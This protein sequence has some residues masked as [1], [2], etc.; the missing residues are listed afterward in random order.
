[1]QTNI[2][3]EA[4]RRQRRKRGCASLEVDTG[5]STEAVGL[6]LEERQ[7][8]KEKFQC[9]GAAEGRGEIDPT[10]R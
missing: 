8:Y 9:K 10:W 5:S 7:R 4:T 6:R 2:R 1:M 3:S